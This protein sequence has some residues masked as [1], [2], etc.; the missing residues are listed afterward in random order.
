MAIGVSQFQVPSFEQSNPFLTG[1]G[2]GQ[3]LFQQFMQ[4]QYLRPLLQQEL[5]KAQLA[6][7]IQAIQAQYAGPQ[8][9]AELGYKK[10]QTGYVGAQTGAIPSEIK[11]REAQMK[12]ALTRAGLT[13]AQAEQVRKEMPY[14]IAAAKMSVFKDPTLNR[15]AE[16]NYARQ[17]GIPQNI[18]AEGGFGAPSAQVPPGAP[19]QAVP[20]PGAPSNVNPL[21]SPQAFTGDA[22]R[23]F[24]AFGSPINP[25][26]ME[27]LKAGISQTA[28]SNVTEW[29]KGLEEAKSAGDLGYNLMNGAK[30]F[31]E[32]YDKAKYKGKQFGKLP[33]SGLFA[34]GGEAEEQTDAF[35]KILQSA[36][37]KML[38]GAKLTN[39]ELQ[40]TGGTKPQREMTEEGAHK[41]GNFYLEK[42]KRLREYDP[43]LVAAQQKGITRPQADALWSMF[44]NQKPSFDFE[45]GKATNFHKDWR[46]YLSDE[47]INAIKSGGYYIPKMDTPEKITLKDIKYLMPDDIDSVPKA[48]FDRMPADVKKEL[49][50]RRLQYQG[51]S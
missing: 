1:L 6:N 34:V 35:S 10:A 16:L 30:G 44:N 11:L 46:E 47:A 50:N 28:K 9:E 43:F 20:V 24:A 19:S 7:Q 22:I 21:T 31:L 41:L 13:S 49:Y 39:Y 45:A 27:G 3:A 18:L 37:A 15:L 32:N 48:V 26:E 17:G 51:G 14:H 12:E 2:H 42:G 40:F 29:N 33:S 23:N 8:A 36:E 38:G 5:Q 4:N 25:L